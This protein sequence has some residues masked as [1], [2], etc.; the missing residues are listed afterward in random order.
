MDTEAAHHAAALLGSPVR[1]R[2]VDALAH[3]DAEADTPGRTAAELG[4][5]VGLHVTTVRFHLDQLAAA[6]LVESVVRRAGGAGRPRKV[7]SLAPGS[8]DDVDPRAQVDHLRL[9]SGLLASTLTEGVAG[10]A[11]TP[12]EAGRRW[13]VEHVPS[14]SSPPADSPGRW[15]G[16][17]AQMIDVLQ[18]WGYTPELKTSD[19]GRTA[20][21][22]LAHCPFL[23]LARENP[24]V[25]CGIH[26]GLIAGS[27]AQLGER[28]ARVSLEPFVDDTTCIAQVSTTTPFRT[29]ASKEHS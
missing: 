20:E 11:M 1:R 28:G 26:R 6:G 14:E 16:K 4:A 5:E 12:A 17:V 29:A 23:D 7:Y 3:A 22:T 24:A 2:L 25:V 9:L 8:L 27:L 18:E 10:H 19:G 21:I 13:A 15:I